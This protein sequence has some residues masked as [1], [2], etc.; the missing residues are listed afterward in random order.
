M[1]ISQKNIKNKIDKQNNKEN[2]KINNNIINNSFGRSN[3]NNEIGKCFTD[4]I[5][6]YRFEHYYNRY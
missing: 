5:Y 3:E 6:I 4:V 2:I 1:E